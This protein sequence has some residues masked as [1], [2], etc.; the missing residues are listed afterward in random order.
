MTEEEI[1]KTSDIINK[2]HRDDKLI[3]ATILLL[4]PPKAE[5]GPLLYSSNS[6]KRRDDFKAYEGIPRK[7]IT[8]YHNP[9]TGIAYETIVN[10]DDGLIETSRRLPKDV[11]P[12]VTNYD[13]ADV[14]TKVTL[15]DPRILRRF[16]KLGIDLKNVVVKLGSTYVPISS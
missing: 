11:L 3:Y 7:T 8:A 16:K 13:S 14:P 15:S 4:E 5:L 2:E 1:H 10:L 6:S 9:F 12:L